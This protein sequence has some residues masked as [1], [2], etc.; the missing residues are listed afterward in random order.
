MNPTPTTMNLLNTKPR[1]WNWKP[2]EDITAYE[3]AQCIPVLSRHFVELFSVI[4][5]LPEN[6]RRHFEEIK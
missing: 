2:K 1:M 5:S 6:L 3:L 4:E